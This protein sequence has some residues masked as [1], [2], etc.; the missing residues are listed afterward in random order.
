MKEANSLETL[1]TL[2]ENATDLA[3]HFHKQ[4][5]EAEDHYK[6]CMSLIDKIDEEIRR[7]IE[8]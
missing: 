5:V 2:R 1:L 7:V 6:E 8:I 3:Y 4:K